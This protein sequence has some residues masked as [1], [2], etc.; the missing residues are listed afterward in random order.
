ML[1]RECKKQNLC[2]ELCPKALRFVN[3]DF[4][5]LREKTIGLPEYGEPIVPPIKFSKRE[6]EVVSLLAQNFSRKEICKLLNVKRE[7]LEN[8]ISRARRKML[9]TYPF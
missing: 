6:K 8:I 5:P 3:Q 7:N 1:C 9:E 2:K 4:V